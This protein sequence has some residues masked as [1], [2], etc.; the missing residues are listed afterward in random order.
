[1]KRESSARSRFRALLSQLASL[2]VADARRMA[3]D[4]PAAV[5]ALRVRM[6]KLRA[7]LLL[8]TA[9]PGDESL[10]PLVT[11]M[12]AIKDG[13]ASGRDALVTE[14]LANKLTGGRL[15]LPPGPRTREWSAQRVLRET[16]ALRAAL[17]ALTLKPQSKAAIFRRYRA[18]CR[19]ERKAM[20]RCRHS[21]RAENFHRWRKR[22]KTCYYQSL[23]LHRWLPG[24]KHL[25][26]ASKLAHRLGEEHDLALLKARVPASGDAK[27]WRDLFEHK[28]RS[29][30]HRL[31]H[32]RK[33]I[34]RKPPQLSGSR[35]SAR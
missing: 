26:A 19:R 14:R 6:K 28:R 10:T 4:R 18:N 23:A 27:A 17:E 15:S 2:A 34:C 22:V 9:D 35:G 16:K 12:K 33:K 3:V 30:H 1:M 25:R 31:L 24:F 29:L 20:E 8:T 13:L 11:R 5:H 7:V 21:H 32:K